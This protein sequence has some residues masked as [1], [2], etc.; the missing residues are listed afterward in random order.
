MD[1]LGWKVR[2][3]EGE[4]DG[5]KGGKDGLDVHKEIIALNFS[6]SLNIFLSIFFHPFVVN[7]C[8]QVADASCV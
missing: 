6:L 2:V 5:G 3:G 1:S 8:K 4:G 7:S